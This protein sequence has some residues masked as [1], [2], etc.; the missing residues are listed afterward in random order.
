MKGSLCN[1]H[2]GE[3]E[4][5][6]SCCRGHWVSNAFR[7]SSTWY[8]SF[9]F[10]VRLLCMFTWMSLQVYQNYPVSAS[11]FCIPKNL[12][13][14]HVWRMF[15]T[16][17]EKWGRCDPLTVIGN[18]PF[19]SIFMSSEFCIPWLL[20]LDVSFLPKW[21]LFIYFGVVILS[22]CW[23][24]APQSNHISSQNRWLHHIHYELSLVPLSKNLYWW[25]KAR[26]MTT[27]KMTLG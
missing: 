26:L 15:E 9:V 19:I 14:W 13:L 12:C 2:S 7:I 5:V 18:F 3:P 16:F 8:A 27:I 24:Y 11:I 25:D 22:P 21:F 20:Y 1:L 4:E 23:L 10:L 17:K 6:G